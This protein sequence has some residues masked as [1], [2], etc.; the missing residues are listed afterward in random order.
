MTMDETQHGT[1]VHLNR[2]MTVITATAARSSAAH[3]ES[4]HR[5]AA[6]EDAPNVDMDPR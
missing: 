3:P 2:P 5:S 6:V 1:A 4:D